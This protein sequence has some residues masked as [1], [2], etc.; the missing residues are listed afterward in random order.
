MTLPFGRKYARWEDRVWCY[1]MRALHEASNNVLSAY[2]TECRNQWV[3]E[4][5]QLHSEAIG[6]GSK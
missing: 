1:C 3:A 2:Q 6:W 5:W 4:Y